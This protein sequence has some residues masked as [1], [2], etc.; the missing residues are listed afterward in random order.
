LTLRNME[1]NN[2]IMDMREAEPHL[3]EPRNRLYIFN[4][5]NLEAERWLLEHYPNG[6]L[7]RFQAFIPEK[8]FMIFFAPA[9]T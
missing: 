8:D 3:L 4:P 2:L 7:M 9:G 5:V 1:W 6:R